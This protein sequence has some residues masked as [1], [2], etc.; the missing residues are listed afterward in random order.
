MTGRIP[1]AFIDDL[2]T[3]VDIVDLIGNR[4]PLKKAG[5]DYQAR[6]PFH[7]EKTPSFT[8]S[9]DKQFYH[10]FGCGAHGTAIGFLMEY[11]R[12]GFL[13]A[14][15]ALAR[16]AG[17]EVPGE[18]DAP[19]G[20]DTRP[21]F[22]LLEQA[23][24]YYRSQLKIHAQAID[25]LKRRGLS[26]RTA[27]AFGIGYAP[28]GWDNLLRHLGTGRDALERL[29]ATGMLALNEGRR[30]DRFRDRIMFPIRDQRGRTIAFGGRVLGDDKPKYLNSPETPL[31]HKGRELYGLFEARRALRQ[32]ERA[33]V[34]EGYM[35]VIALAQFGVPYALATLG[36][37]VTPEHLDRVFRT[38][39]EVV[40]CLDGDRAGR[41][42]AWKALNNA[43]PLMREGR[44]ARFLFLPQGEDPD[45]IIRREGQDGFE[46]RIRN[47]IPLSD[48]LF[49]KLSQGLDTASLDG[50]ARLA[51]QAKPLLNR[52]PAG[53]FREMMYQRLAEMVDLPPAKLG[54]QRPAGPGHP[55]R[56]P[57]RRTGPRRIS[58]QLRA[59]ALLLQYPQLA[60]Q[61]PAL[62][63]TW[64][65]C[66]APGAA[67]FGEILDLLR[68]EPN[69]TTAV[70][71]ERWRDTE[72]GTHLAKAAALD[73]AVPEGDEAQEFVGAVQ[74]LTEQYRE[75][76][77]ERLLKK[78]STAPVTASEKQRLTQLLR[79]QSEKGV[80]E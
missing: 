44:Q 47:A 71:L 61:C 67:L 75:Q 13:E 31:F 23:A 1:Q 46:Q 52:L 6:C 70:L 59:I 42:A 65:A 79:A 51:E 38:T 72:E 74:R 22:Q 14:V 8:V 3:R 34:V 78:S 76:E 18:S 58:L 57:L 32:M 77:L 64:Q 2:L 66:Q 12:L 80:K 27:A 33:V 39:P 37:A 40:F 45:S 56:R 26:G 19:K 15:E 41:D 16:Q 25:Y 17:V 24:N 5:K 10:C 63:P 28:P 49:D 4:V 73:L 54:G 30:Y 36:T 50:R 20:P 43:L 55:T 69:L 48:F 53:V 29:E 60:R 11:E 9:Q 68:I 35:D 62:D 7:D 21:L